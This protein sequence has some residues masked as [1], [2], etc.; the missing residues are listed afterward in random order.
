M[1]VSGSNRETSDLLPF[2]SRSDRPLS[3]GGFLV[4]CKRVADVETLQSCKTSFRIM[5]ETNRSFSIEFK[6]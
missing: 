6:L 4:A 2:T 5:S 3:I 1:L